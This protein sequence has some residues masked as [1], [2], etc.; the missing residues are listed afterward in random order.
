[1]VKDNQGGEVKQALKIYVETDE[2]ENIAVVSSKNSVNSAAKKIK[3]LV[4]ASL[5]K[6][7]ALAPL[8]MVKT[9]GVVKV[10]PGN[11][12]TQMFF[13]VDPLSGAGLPVYMNSRDFPPIKIGDEVEVTGELGTYLGTVRVKIKEKKDIDI[14]SIDNLKEPLAV[15]TGDID[16]D[17]FFSLVQMEGEV[18][19]TG[20]GYFY[21][22]D[23]M[24]EIQVQLKSRTGLKGKVAS[25]GDKVKVT[26]I[27]G[28]SK[29][30]W[31]LWPRGA[32]DVNILDVG[33]PIDN[34]TTADVTEK[35]LTATAGGVTSLLL[36]LLAKGRGA[37]AKAIAFGF[38]GKIA[39]WKKRDKV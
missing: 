4:V 35:Y 19:E 16:D 5:D 10:P 3:S 6:I 39:F 9:K 14:L 8:T 15:N 7:S 37:I 25:V 17:K 36:A 27:I 33:K 28:K 21:L 29:D 18:L 30:T 2:E 1:M 34:G 22:G 13:I 24:G 38:I 32:E 31:V 20:S 11:F 26:G 23:E 12:S